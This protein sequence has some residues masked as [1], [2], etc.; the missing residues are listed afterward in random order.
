MLSMIQHRSW[1][2]CLLV[3]VLVGDRIFLARPIKRLQQRL[4]ER[5]DVA[6]VEREDIF[7]LIN[8]LLEQTHLLFREEG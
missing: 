3:V 5:S 1:I 6:L 4:D 2:I 7:L 8:V